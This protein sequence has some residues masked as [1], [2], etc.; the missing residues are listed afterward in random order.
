MIRAEYVCELCL[1]A[2]QTMDDLLA[3]PCPRMTSSGSQKI[4]MKVELEL[5]E[6][7]KQLHYAADYKE[8]RRLEL[9]KQLEVEQRKLAKLMQMKFKCFLAVRCCVINL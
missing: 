8:R 9:H 3:K 6:A 1:Y 4:S 5:L 7:R 2:G